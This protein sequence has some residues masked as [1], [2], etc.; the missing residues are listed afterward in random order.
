MHHLPP[1][2]RLKAV[3][4][5]LMIMTYENYRDGMQRQ[6]AKVQDYCNPYMPS[7][8]DVCGFRHP[9]PDMLMGCYRTDCVPSSNGQPRSELNRC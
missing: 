5:I 9:H 8:I 1:R 7:V 6:R 2:V 4:C 3:G